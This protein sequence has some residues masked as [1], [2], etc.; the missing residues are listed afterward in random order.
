MI[1]ESLTFLAYPK[2]S[3]V[4]SPGVILHFFSAES[5]LTPRTRVSTGPFEEAAQPMNAKVGTEVARGW[6]WWHLKH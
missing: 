5:K 3:V 1:R 4:G 2:K 6:F